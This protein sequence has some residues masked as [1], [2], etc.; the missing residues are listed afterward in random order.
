MKI[1]SNRIKL[2]RIEKKLSQKKLS[3]L[4]GLKEST[5]SS[6]ETGNSS[7]DVDKLKKIA[8]ALGT[9]TDYLI[10]LSNN[11]I[12]ENIAND[13]KIVIKTI[14]EKSLST[15]DIDY[16]LKLKDSFKSLPD[17]EIINKVKTILNTPFE[18]FIK[19]KEL[20][21][22]E[23]PYTDIKIF[24]DNWKEQNKER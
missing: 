17:V 20:I 22:N 16:L 1:L 21:G 3:K 10:G 6:Y 2:R 4:I 12:G 9:T 14:E 24:V 23:I 19:V 18:D 11:K 7:P 5:I 15:D 8:L 13:T